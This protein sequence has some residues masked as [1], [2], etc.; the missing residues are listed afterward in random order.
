MQITDVTQTQSYH[1]I[2]DQKEWCAWSMRH[3]YRLARLI[4]EALWY[5][6]CVVLTHHNGV[7]QTI[8]FRLDAF[9][10]KYKF[11]FKKRRT[12]PRNSEKIR[13][14]LIGNNYSTV[15]QVMSYM[16]LWYNLRGRA[17]WPIIVIK[18]PVYA[19]YL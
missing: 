8:G 4:H 13:I 11:I 6:H 3:F 18:T 14:K 7:H 10:P 12:C 1:L 17:I 5:T 9:Y 2:S 16:W 19:F 15:R